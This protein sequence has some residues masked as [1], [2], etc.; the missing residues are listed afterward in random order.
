MR[1]SDLPQVKA[2]D[3]FETMSEESFARLMQAAY[4]QTFPAQLALVHEGD[5]ADFLYVLIEGAVELFAAAN[6]REET[7]AVV[8]PVETFILAAVLKDAVYL[9]AAR[10]IV[11]SRILLIPAA[12]V[13]RAFQEDEAFARAIVSELAT[14]Y[15]GVVK[16]HKN[17][18]LRSSVE[19]LAN[20]LIRYDAEQGATGVVELPYEKRI[21]A[22][23]LSMTPENLSRAFKTLKP[24][25][26]E[27]DGMTV[28]LK[29]MKALEV[30]AK[31]NAFID[32]DR[33]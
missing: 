30:L 15:R 25:G 6:G 21:L 24:Y 26:V 27:V 13:R 2:L 17:I 7:M 10:T 3:L 9:M 12:D 16:E 1:S 4:L 5:P 28:R 23:L 29:D 14:R 19:R 22:S 33:R 8:R 20:R 11:R 32:D 31:P 18:K